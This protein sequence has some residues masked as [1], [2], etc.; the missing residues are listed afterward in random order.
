[1]KR[2]EIMATFRSLARSQGLYGRILNEIN[3]MSESERNRVFEELES[4]NFKDSLDLIMYI[5]C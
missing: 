4:Q 3:S 1:M 5:E 2:N